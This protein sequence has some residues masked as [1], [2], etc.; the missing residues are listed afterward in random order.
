MTTKQMATQVRLEHWAKVLRE[1]KSSGLSIR[2]WCRENGVNEKT[3]YY[4]QRK[5]R[6]SVCE[7]LNGEVP[8]PLLPATFAQVRMPESETFG[9]KMVIRLNGAEV[10]IHGDMPA[11]TV[12]AA[13]NALLGR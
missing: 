12:D 13:L 3:Y 2:R 6:E 4:W 5:L 1:R 11:D 10:E 7:N 8:E 9:A